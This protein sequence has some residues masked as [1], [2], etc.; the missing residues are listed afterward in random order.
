MK[1]AGIVV[2]VVFAL[3][4]LGVGF[5]GATA[6]LDITQPSISYSS[7]AVK[8]VVQQGDTT[9]AV[10]QRLQA[11]GLIRN[12][13]L[14]RAW[15]RYRH[16]DTGIEPGVYTL[17]P[18]MTMDQII[19]KLQRGQPDQVVATIQDGW[20]VTQFPDGLSG[21]PDFKSQD[22]LQIVKTGKF[23]DGTTVA[24]KYWY[25]LPPQSE[26]HVY[27]ALEGYL[28]P[29]TYYF[30]T[31]ATAQ[32]VV[33]RML[34]TLGEH[35]C[36]GPDNQPDAYALDQAQCKAHAAQ[37]GNTTIFAA[38]E[39]AYGTTNDAQALFDTLTMASIV[40]REIKNY[41]DA[42]AV[43]S[44]YYNR[45]L[46]FNNKLASPPGDY[47]GMFGAD[48]TVQYARDSDNPPQNGKWWTALNNTGGNVDPN[49][50]YNTYKHAG[51]PPGPIA[52]PLWKEIVAAATPQSTPYFYFY[53]DN[54]GINHYFKTIADQQAAIPSLQNVKCP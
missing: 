50:L 44:L 49:S 45:Y 39:K 15:A 12:A 46:V 43:A 13:L 52:A 34:L 11:A 9:A 40:A 42:T 21:L 18:G 4:A 38:M 31:T 19:Q 6:V 16:L 24:S 51:L 5:A 25:V 1:R 22:F 26:P 17:S 47:V 32:D 20:R 36:P 35:L 3:I 2:T 54:C 53:S 8:F 23:L 29:D 10:A 30:D 41:N 33:N 27:Y 28:Y 48:P 14:F 37:V 7:M